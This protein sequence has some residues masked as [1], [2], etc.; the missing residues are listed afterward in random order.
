MRKNTLTSYRGREMQKER[1][2]FLLNSWVNKKPN[3]VEWRYEAK[4]RILKC[5][6]NKAELL[7]LSKLKISALPPSNLPIMPHVKTLNLS[8]N[9]LEFLPFGIHK[10]FPNLEELNLDGN[11]FVRIPDQVMF[12]SQLVVLSVK[13]NQLKWVGPEIANLRRLEQFLLQNNSQ[14][15]TIAPEIMQLPRLKTLF[16]IPEAD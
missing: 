5:L 13:N 1:I 14:L 2:E 12:L 9:Q 10:S 16:V 7:D 8:H 15:K 11:K 4:Q 3:E 6:T